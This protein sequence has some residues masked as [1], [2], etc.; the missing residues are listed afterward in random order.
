M[1]GIT[2][3]GQV[4]STG[5][6]T[7]PHKHVYVKDLGT[8]QYIDPSTI[9][10]ALAGIRVGEQRIPA[11]TKTKDGKYDINPQSGIAV[12]SK[13]GP[14]SAPTK[15]ASTF[16]QGEDW[17][18]PEG[19]PVYFEGAGTYKPLANQGGYGNLATF[20]T[21]DNKYEI[22]LGHMKSLGKPG[23]TAL[24]TTPTAAQPSTDSRTED[25]LKAFMY[26]A[27]FQGKEPEKPKKTMQE[28]LK[29]QLVGGLISQALNP[30]GF[31]D[32]YRTENPL[33]MGQSSATLDYL[34]GLFG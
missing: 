3:L 18:L 21:G 25:I 33:L 16:H 32:S 31:L 15:G 17:A 7:G 11:L 29:E 6:S 26:G 24:P 1:A 23:A 20:T 19:T 12:T 14:R 8:G 27:G 9:R 4:G 30:M 2:Y 10:S 13:F 34:N 22:G 5:T 28:T